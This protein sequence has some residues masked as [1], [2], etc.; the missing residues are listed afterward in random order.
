[1]PDAMRVARTAAAGALGLASK[2]ME[3]GAFAT[4]ML[5][6]KLAADGGRRPA[7]PSGRARGDEGPGPLR[8]AEARLSPPEPERR[9]AGR[10]SAPPSD[11][12]PLVDQHVRTYETHVE[13]LAA[14]SAGDVI[15]E[16]T[17]LSTDELRA[18][19]EHES[20]NKKRKTVL[21][22]IEAQLVPTG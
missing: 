6:R 16:V 17:K 14:R 9:E 2:G 10:V 13:E 22:A 8:V 18:L 21:Q 19:W 12:V 11:P 1:M 4:R 5:A 7:P 20:A 15:N 3:L